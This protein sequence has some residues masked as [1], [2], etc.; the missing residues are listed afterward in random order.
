MCPVEGVWYENNAPKSFNQKYLH[1]FTCNNGLRHFLLIAVKCLHAI[2]YTPNEW[3]AFKVYHTDETY[4]ARKIY[5]QTTDGE[6]NGDKFIAKAAETTSHL[7]KGARCCIC[8]CS[9][10]TIQFINPADSSP[11]NQRE[12]QCT[13]MV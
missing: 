8:A 5:T 4:R 3:V 12:H 7:A 9:Q 11:K 10:S 6:I 13:Q 1:T 2:Q